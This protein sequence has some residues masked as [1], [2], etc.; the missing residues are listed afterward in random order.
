[1][2]TILLII[3]TYSGQQRAPLFPILVFFPYYLNINSSNLQLFIHQPGVFLTDLVFVDDGNSDY[4]PKTNMI[5]MAKLKFIASILFII[6]RCKLTRY[7]FTP[8]PSL[9]ASLLTLS[10]MSEEQQRE[11]SLQCEPRN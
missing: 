11:L 8:I 3:E 2:T 5:N 10:S 9:Q 1:M 7:D 4:K 6:E